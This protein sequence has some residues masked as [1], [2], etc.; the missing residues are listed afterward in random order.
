MSGGTRPRDKIVARDLSLSYTNEATGSSHT[1]LDGFDLSVRG[2]EFLAV[3]GPS[4]CGKSTFLSVLAGL[5]PQTSGEITVDGEPV[6]AARQKLGLVFQGYALFPWRTVRKNV[7]TGLEIRGVKG[8]QRRSEAERFLR[9]VGLLD[10]A[11][12]YPHQLSGGMRQRVAI[13]RVLAYG[14]EILLMDEPF[15]ALDA[16]TRESLQQ[17]LLGIWEHSAKT[18]VFVTHSIDEAIFLADRVAIMGRGPGRVKEIMEIDLPR[19][20]HASIRHSGAFVALRERAWT[21]LSQELGEQR[22]PAVRITE[23]NDA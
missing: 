6:S 3:L 1:V 18:V 19:P 9:L 8:A 11:D 20:R 16:Q 22:S 13:A 7:E 10:F 2:G 14:P 21:S 17:E 4:G 23:L 5:V 15:G 12:H